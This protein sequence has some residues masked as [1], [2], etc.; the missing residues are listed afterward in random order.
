MRNVFKS[1]YSENYFCG[2]YDKS[3]FNIDSSKILVSKPNFIDR[4][5]EKDDV[6]EIGFFEWKKSKKFIKI[7]ET[8]AWNWQQ[9][10]MLQ[11]LGPDFN[12]KIIYNDRVK[13]KFVT[14]IY[15]INK[16]KKSIL[17]LSFYS[18]SSN[19]NF[20]ICID[21]ERLCW[22]R[23]GYSYSGIMNFDKKKRL[24]EDDGIWNINIITN[25]KKLIINLKDIVKIKPLSNMIGA[26]HYLEHIIISPNNE[27]IAFLH[28]YKTTDGGLF[29]RLFTA[30]I[31]GSE[32][33]LL[34]DSGRVTHYNWKNNSEIICWGALNNSFNNLRKY[35]SLIKYFFTPIL[36]LYKS[37][38]RGNSID[39]NSKLS[40]VLTGDRYLLLKDKSK[41]S[42]SI[43]TTI[44]NKDGHP[45]FSK[46]N[47]NL[48]LTD[49]YPQS[50]NHFKQDLILYDVSNNNYTIEQISHLPEHAYAINRCDLHPKWSMDEKYICV[51]SLRNKRSIEIYEI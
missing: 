4:F 38:V 7:S 1:E 34:N 42:K 28:R 47:Q 50:K 20:A 6:L 25:K 29:T 30:N 45:S 48:L 33:F 23:K 16:K 36:P 5:P 18:V 15:D 8:K 19:G 39:G 17:D 37:I 35:K 22:Y 14:V 49:T 3:P 13:N 26:T 10:C 40:S 43:S 9:G 46:K 31:D 24:P 11:W 2:Y 12:S 27:R 21:N 44:L 51:D 41:K 32:L